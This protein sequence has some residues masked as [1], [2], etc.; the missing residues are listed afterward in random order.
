MMSVVLGGMSVVWLLWHA[1]AVRGSYVLVLL[2]DSE[3]GVVS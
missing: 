2:V 1:C 3:I